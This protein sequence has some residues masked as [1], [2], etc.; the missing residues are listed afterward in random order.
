MKTACV[1]NGMFAKS[2]S[3]YN[4]ITHWSIVINAFQ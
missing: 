1:Y 3:Y 2:D 4:V